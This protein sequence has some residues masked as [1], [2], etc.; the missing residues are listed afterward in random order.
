MGCLRGQWSSGRLNPIQLFGPMAVLETHVLTHILMLLPHW[1][2]G[3][4]GGLPNFTHFHLSSPFAHFLLIFVYVLLSRGGAPPRTRSL[5]GGHARGA[6]APS[7]SS[8]GGRTR[9]GK[10]H[11]TRKIHKG[12]TNQKGMQT[13]Q[14]REQILT[15]GGVNSAGVRLAPGIRGPLALGG[16][17]HP[18]TQ[19]CSNS[20]N[21]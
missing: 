7:T 2:Y 11:A 6:I 12:R 9:V 10:I 8:P 13:P 17:S 14:R 3:I 16:Q 1:G 18:C 19:L 20:S 15:L 4:F 21:S 5:V